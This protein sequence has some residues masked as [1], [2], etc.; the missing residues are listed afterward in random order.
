MKAIKKIKAK[1]N[2][3]K[4]LGYSLRLIKARIQARIDKLEDKKGSNL[5][6][7]QRAE[8]FATDVTK[9]MREWST[10]KAYEA[11]SKNAG[12]T[13]EQAELKQLIK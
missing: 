13:M 1:I 7:A 12:L 3:F 11:V 5:E 4:F 8:K 6:S 9:A 10:K 2:M